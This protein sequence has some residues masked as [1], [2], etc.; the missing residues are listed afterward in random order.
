MRMDLE[1]VGW[2]TGSEL[3]HQ[4]TQ[5]LLAASGGEDHVSHAT[6]GLLDRGLGDAEQQPRLAGHPTQ[7]VQQLLVTASFP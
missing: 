5:R 3:A 7:V 6:V 2:P 1:A 4:I